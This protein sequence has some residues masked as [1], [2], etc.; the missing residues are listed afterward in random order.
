MALGLLWLSATKQGVQMETFL[1]SD[2]SPPAL[3]ATDL[4]GLTLESKLAKPSVLKEGL[5]KS[6][7]CIQNTIVLIF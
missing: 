5:E 1:Y 3:N 2:S 7:T 4:N 6:R